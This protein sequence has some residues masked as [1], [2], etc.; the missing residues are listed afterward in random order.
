M[1]FLTVTKNDCIFG[2]HTAIL[3]KTNKEQKPQQEY[4]PAFGLENRQR[5]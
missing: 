4:F 3:G 2:G 1:F 5:H